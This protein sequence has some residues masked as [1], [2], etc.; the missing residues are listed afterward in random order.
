MNSL[1]FDVVAHRVAAYTLA[2][3][4]AA[5]GGVLLVWY[6]G[7]VTPGTVG[8]GALIKI[9]IIAVLGGMRHPLGAFIGAVIYVLLQ[10]FAIDLNDRER[11]TRY[12]RR[13]SRDRAVS[14]DGCSDSGRRRLRFRTAEAAGNPRPS[15]RH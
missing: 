12:R 1:G 15:R 7:L 11:F 4:L 5:V 2:G 8:T 6:D 3:F 10:N 13:L 9:L 14:P